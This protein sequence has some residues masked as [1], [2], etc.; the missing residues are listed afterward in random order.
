MSN[1]LPKLYDG[2]MHK[3]IR[4][5]LEYTADKYGDLTAFIL[6][7]KVKKEVSYEDISYIQLRDD[8]IGLSTYMTENG[9]K[10]TRVAVIGST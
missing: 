10:D 7:H 1:H 5:L 3:D 9:F 8:V 6:K 4:D 2:T